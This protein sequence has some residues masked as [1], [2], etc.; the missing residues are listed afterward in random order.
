MKRAFADH[1]V[2]TDRL[3]SGQLTRIPHRQWLSRDPIGRLALMHGLLT[4]LDIDLLL[5]EQSTEGGYF[6]E[7]AMRHGLL[8][9]SQLEILLTG[10]AIRACLDLV[11]DLALADVLDIPTGL[12]A[13]S[14]FTNLDEFTQSLEPDAARAS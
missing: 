12:A 2:T 1:L 14:E 4:G 3:S 10:Q 11:E 13:L 6:G 9:R 8:S 5:R 7:I